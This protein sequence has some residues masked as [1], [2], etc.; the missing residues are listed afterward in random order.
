MPDVPCTNQPSHSVLRALV[1]LVLLQQPAT[2]TPATHHHTAP[3]TTPAGLSP[4]RPVSPRNPSTPKHAIPALPPSPPLLALLRWVRFSLGL[5]STTLPPLPSPLPPSPSLPSPTPVTIAAT[6]ALP[7]DC[8]SSTTSLT[9][10]VCNPCPTPATG[11]SSAWITAISKEWS[12]A[13]SS[14]RTCCSS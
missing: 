14:P 10:H 7:H 13:T 1:F 8:V 4:C 9:N 3:T 2:T 5:V 12:T 11:S 6:S